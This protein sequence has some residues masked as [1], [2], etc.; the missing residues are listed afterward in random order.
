MAA[1]IPL[2]L[3]EIAAME[4]TTFL[5][6][7]QVSRVLSCSPYTI[8]VAAKD[9]KGRARLGF[10]VTMMGNRVKIPRIPFLHFMGWEGPIA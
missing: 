9:E 4:G 10:P 3:E 1:K 2:S 7:V 6:P 8:N 5:V